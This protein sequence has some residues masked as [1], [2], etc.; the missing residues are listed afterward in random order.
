MRALVVYES[1]FG[2]T[3]EIAS[4]IAQ[5]VRDAGCSAEL[6][7]VSHAPTAIDVF[8]LV[9]VGG[10]THAWS[11]SRASTREGGRKQARALDRTPESSGIGVREWLAQL[12]PT[13]DQ[14]PVPAAT[15]DTA[16]KT[17]WFPVGS[18]ARAEAKA[19]QHMGHAILEKPE[20]FYVGDSAGPLIDGERERART[21]ASRIVTAHLD[22][23]AGIE[24]RDA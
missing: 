11:M 13:P 4:A 5:G 7:E 17:R 16:V 10:P 15:F 14:P 22:R 6:V 2:N 24:A 9:I 19:L 20:H 1:I 3:R 12:V 8:D 23:T 21:W 18:A